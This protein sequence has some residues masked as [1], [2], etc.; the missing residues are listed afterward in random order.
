MNTPVDDISIKADRLREESTDHISQMQPTDLVP[1]PDDL[2]ETVLLRTPTA[3]P[4]TQR[5]DC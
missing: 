1:V 4:T 2:H 5:V 3:K